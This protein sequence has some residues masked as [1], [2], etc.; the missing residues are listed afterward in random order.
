LTVGGAYAI[1]KVEIEKG[2][3]EMTNA[4]KMTTTW[5]AYKGARARYENTEYRVKTGQSGPTT[6]TLMQRESEMK[7]AW[8]AWQAECKA[9]AK[10][11][12]QYITTR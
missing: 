10:R 6:T 8:D 9:S 1:I 12:S 7:M 2:E 5:I 3:H 4:D 11:M